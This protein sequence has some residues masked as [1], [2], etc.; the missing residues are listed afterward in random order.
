MRSS[1]EAPTILIPLVLVTD[2]DRALGVILAAIVQKKIYMEDNHVLFINLFYT[3][4]VA[5]SSYCCNILFTLC[6]HD[7]HVVTSRR[8]SEVLPSALLGDLRERVLNEYFSILV[9]TPGAKFYQ[10]KIAGTICLLIY[11]G[12]T[13]TIIGVCT[14]Q[15]EYLMN[16]S[17]FIHTHIYV[18]CTTPSNGAPPSD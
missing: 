18:Y 17:I 2:W 16:N 14:V 5:F 11:P 10:T 4:I 6:R 9:S 3:R 12:S 13:S 15:R 7:L 8:K 1:T